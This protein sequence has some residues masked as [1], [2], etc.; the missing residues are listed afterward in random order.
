MLVYD[1]CAIP[2]I[3]YNLFAVPHVVIVGTV[4]VV[5]GKICK[6]SGCSL[7]ITDP[8][9]RT[10]FS[11]PEDREEER[12]GWGITRVRFRADGRERVGGRYSLTLVIGQPPPGGAVEHIG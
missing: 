8:Q 9:R 10:C 4:P 1:P 3:V 11:W 2:C 5:K 12:L 7:C 6:M